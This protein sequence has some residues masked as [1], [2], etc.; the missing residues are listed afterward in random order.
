VSTLIIVAGIF[1][2]DKKK[3]RVENTPS[4]PSRS[5]EKLI[6][7]LYSK[8]TVSGIEKQKTSSHP[9]YSFY[10][11]PANKFLALSLAAKHNKLL[12]ES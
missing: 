7:N 11:L 12:K 8:T 3:I 5:N 9:A 10:I 2:Q 1:A 6:F 4:R